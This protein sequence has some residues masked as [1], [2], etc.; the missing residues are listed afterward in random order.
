MPN[1]TTKLNIAIYQFNPTNGDI[2][3]NAKKINEAALRAKTLGADIF[4][5][6]E[7]A[8]SG[9]TCDDLFLHEGFI[10]KCQKELEQFYSINGITLV[11]GSAYKDSNNNCTYNS[12]F[13]IRDGI[14]LGRYDKHNLPNYGVFD[15][16]RY[17]VP[18]NNSLVIDQAGIKF[19]FL[20]CED[21]WSSEPIST[22]KNLNAEVVCI[23]NA[24]PYDYSKH[25]LRRQNL[26]MRAQETNLP[27]IYV[28][29]VGGQDEVVFDGA[30]LIVDCKGETILQMPAFKE[31]LIL[32]QLKAR[33]NKLGFESLNFLSQP[34]PSKFEG[35]YKALILAIQ[36][37]FGKNNFNKALVGLSGGIDSA[38]TL[39]LA[40]DALD[41]DNVLAVMLPSI[42]TSNL[43]LS[44]TRT[45]VATLKTPY[46]EISI[47]SLF[48]EFSQ[49][50]DP[51][52]DKFNNSC[53]ITYQNLQARIRGTLLM[54]LSNQLGY[55]VLNTSNKSELAVGYS[56]LYGD[57][58][59]GF[60]PLKDVAKTLVYELAKWRNLQGLVIPNG[61]I[62]RAPTAELAPNQLDQD[63]LPPYEVLDQIIELLVE[64]R[65]TGQDIINKGFEAN[66]VN[67]VISLV[68]NSEYKRKQSALGPKV[69]PIAFAKEWRYPITN[70]YEF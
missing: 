41:S 53:D 37:Y 25:V 58:V 19:G 65:L 43:S 46:Q 39:T 5:T 4:I 6:S 26:K 31:E 15:E 57:M 50:L 1:N 52:F 20:I 7:L 66:T 54:A 56:T 63:A 42:Y 14:L 47:D 3:E 22:L 23:I 69:S 9:Y 8:I 67:K 33:N 10:D 40:C 51:I 12:L 64:Q 24:S 35:I 45:L 44:L 70:K 2:K 13:V 21:C 59:G 36:D 28:N 61:I 16:R 68:K 30:S 38:L 55:L 62:T 18:G 27:L 32:T 11:I 17:F 49:T 48:K 34:Y 29:C 60:A